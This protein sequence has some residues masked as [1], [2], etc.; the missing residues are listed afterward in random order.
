M[1]IRIGMITTK[2]INN[3]VDSSRQIM[4]DVL[5]DG[6]SRKDAIDFIRRLTFRGVC[7]IK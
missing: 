7:K 3:V 4:K 1:A 5:D 2:A 6:G